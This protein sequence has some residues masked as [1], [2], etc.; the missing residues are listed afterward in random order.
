MSSA[1]PD[2]K[3]L[4]ART[5]EWLREVGISTPDELEAAGPVEAYVRLKQARPREVTLVALY[6]LQGALWNIHW[7]EVPAERKAE[8]KQ[9]AAAR[10]C[11]DP[12]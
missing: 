9:E 8:L 6:A 2:L 10:L 7:N 3:N 1:R 11:A 12:A 5:A 4:G